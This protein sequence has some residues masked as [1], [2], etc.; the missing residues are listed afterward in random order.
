M[1]HF[2]DKAKEIKVVDEER[3]LRLDLE[4]EYWYL[5]PTNMFMMK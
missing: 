1:N 5:P 4:N 3:N 2:I